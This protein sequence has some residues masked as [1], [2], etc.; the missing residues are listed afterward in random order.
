M[1]AKTLI[2]SMKNELK[3]ADLSRFSDEQLASLNE[4]CKQWTEKTDS[5]LKQR[6]PK[7]NEEGWL[8][9]QNDFL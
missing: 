2:D 3:R 4:L 8:A 1:D 5:E 6:G 9:K 7:Q